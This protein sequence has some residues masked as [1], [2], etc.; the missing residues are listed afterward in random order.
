[1]AAADH[2]RSASG[3][4]GTTFKTL[5]GLLVATGLRPGG[6]LRLDVGDVDLASGILA[7][8]ELKFVKSPF[9]SARRI[10]PRRLCRG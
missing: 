8:Q 3:L 5:I 6:A 10:G 1:M 9:R 7:I 2:L 4:R